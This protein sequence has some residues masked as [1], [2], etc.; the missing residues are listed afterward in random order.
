MSLVC[1]IYLLRDNAQIPPEWE[2]H[3]RENINR[4]SK[5]SISEFRDSRLFLLKLDLGAFDAPGWHVDERH[6]TAISGD[7]IL[8]HD[9]NVRGRADDLDA[10]AG[11]D[12]AELR[13]LLLRARGYYNL[14]R[15]DRASHR[16]AIAIDRV[17]VRSTYVYRD[18]NVL[19]FSGALRLIET[20][21]GI[22]LTT[23]LQGVLESAAF[24]VPLDARTQ[25]R[26][27]SY[28]LGGSQ[29]LA[30]GG[31][32]STD[33]YWKF[34][35]DACNEEPTQDLDGA[36]DELYREF[37]RAVRLR[38]GQRKAVFSAL[39]GGLDSRSVT[40]ELWRLGLE[41]HSLNISWAGSQDAVLG[42]AYAAKLGLKHHYV[43]RPLEEAGNSL[44]QRLQRLMEENASACADLPSTPL[45]LWSGNGGSLGL[46]H[47]KM[48]PEVT[49]RM[50]SGD[51]EGAARLFL[52]TFKFGLS[53][54][55]LRND[56]ARW[57]ADLPFRSLMKELEQIRCRE[58]ARSLYIFRMEN[59]QRRLLS[60][61]FEQIDLVPF[62]F[63]EPLF[64]PEVLRVV[65][66]L[67]M[68]FC[69]RHHMYHRWLE[70]F[71][72]E[73]LSVAWQVYPG[74]EPC[75]VP[76]PP[77]VFDQ[78]KPPRRVRRGSAFVPSLRQAMQY[79]RERTLFR[80][81]LRTERVIAAYLMK[82]LELRDTS[83]LL[84]QVD[85]LGKPLRISQGRIELPQTAP[86]ASV[87]RAAV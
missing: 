50:A 31:E 17:G 60:F 30:A 64:D 86:D 65:C 2:R 23:D 18:A 47:S 7:A 71:P 10:L 51:V 57:A 58:R 43:E 53:P 85:L 8:V 35:R 33:R 20:L 13:P 72:K 9:V 80:N 49:N 84:R 62:E 15:Y 44:A 16:L 69:L 59:D 27:V 87:A 21:P 81:T 3:L 79:W 70:R 5:G 11:V 25:Y 24:G 34:D 66:K 12:V 22:R 39:S 56:I 73:I 48:D 37:Q 83:H 26:E 29:L 41:V 78:W 46:G 63:I 42:N 32:L 74:H 76:L 28:M 38:T 52:A 4:G 55:L 67:P 1:G 75:P 54:T 82:A 14:V 61:H 36:L 40:T 68:M 77:G 19:V 45:Q 6:V